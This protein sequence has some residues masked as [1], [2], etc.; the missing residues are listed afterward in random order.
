[1]Y[2]A[3]LPSTSPVFGFLRVCGEP[4]YYETRRHAAGTTNLRLDGR[5]KFC[6]TPVVGPIPMYAAEAT[7][8]DIDGERQR[9]APAAGVA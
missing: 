3:H 9:A 8:Q 2:L 7:A 5:A 1:M 6:N 4:C